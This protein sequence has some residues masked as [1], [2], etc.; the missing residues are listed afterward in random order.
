MTG[1]TFPV[2]ILTEDPDNPAAEI[3]KEKTPDPC[4]V[5]IFGATGDLTRR[6]LVPALF[7]LAANRNL[8]DHVTVLGYARRPLS[9]DDFRDQLKGPA[10]G[11]SKAF[12]DETWISPVSST[13]STCDLTRRPT[14]PSIGSSSSP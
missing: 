4:V 12:T 10:S 8:P 3:L 9:A 1:D 5:V 14:T 7:D 2:G 6:K 11:F 13:I